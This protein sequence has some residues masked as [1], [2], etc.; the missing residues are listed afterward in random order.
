MSFRFKQIERSKR[1][2]RKF[3]NADKRTADGCA[4]SRF[5][6][7]VMKKKGYSVRLSML[8]STLPF[9]RF[10]MPPALPVILTVKT[11]RKWAHER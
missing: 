4:R 6:G 7:Q 1:G 2:K 3:K 9:Q 5:V 11:G 10:L 8:A